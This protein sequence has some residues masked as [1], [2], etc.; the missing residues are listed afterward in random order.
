[1]RI[2]SNSGSTLAYAAELFAAV[3][4]E[5]SSRILR[6]ADQEEHHMS[7]SVHLDV[8]TRDEKEVVEKNEQRSDEQNAPNDIVGVTNK[9]KNDEIDTFIGSKHFKSEKSQCSTDQCFTES[10]TTKS[11]S[12]CLLSIQLFFK[13]LQQSLFQRIFFHPLSAKSKQ[14]SSLKSTLQLDS[15]L[16]P[17]R[18]RSWQLPNHDEAQTQL[19]KTELLNILKN[20][21]INLIQ[22]KTVFSCYF[23]V[24]IN[25]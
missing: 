13:N 14:I 22:L 9:R 5:L 2:C 16:F 4:E 8:P 24:Q 21:S 18:P 15:K 6:C 19:L 10:K 1:M 7:I 20:G 11:N 17:I 23:Q 25:K 12:Q 3:D